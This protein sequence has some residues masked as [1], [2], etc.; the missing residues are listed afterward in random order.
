MTLLLPLLQILLLML[1]LLPLLGLLPLLLLLALLL[2]LLLLLGLDAR[3]RGVH[4]ARQRMHARVA[5]RERRERHA[6]PHPA[7]QAKP[8][9]SQEH[10]RRGGTAEHLVSGQYSAQQQRVTHSVTCQVKGEVLFP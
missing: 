1:L 2:L 8:V 5:S 4:H 7:V 10:E 3:G 6:L 9:G